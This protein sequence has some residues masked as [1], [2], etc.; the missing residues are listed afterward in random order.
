MLFT[1]AHQAIQLFPFLLALCIRH[2]Q[3]QNAKSSFCYWMWIALVTFMAA[4]ILHLKHD[5]HWKCDR[6][7]ITRVCVTLVIAA[8]IDS[9]FN[10]KQ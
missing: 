6:V 8:E 9:R 3:K 2:G 4:G 7:S 5:F 1:P 10:F